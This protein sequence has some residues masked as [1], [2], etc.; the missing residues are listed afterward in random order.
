MP[1]QGQIYRWIYF[2]LSL[3][4]LLHFRDILKNIIFQPFLQ[5]FIPEHLSNSFFHR[6]IFF[7]DQFLGLSRVRSAILIVFLI[8][9]WHFLVFYG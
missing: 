5:K 2:L 6:L 3:C 7:T 1:V 8:L 9:I 4:F